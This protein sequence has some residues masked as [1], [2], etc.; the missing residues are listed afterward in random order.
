MV[1]E[2]EPG[3]LLD[4]P[5]DAKKKN[6]NPIREKIDALRAEFQRKIDEKESL[7]QTAESERNEARSAET[8]A[9]QELEDKRAEVNRLNEA[10]R[11]VRASAEEAA[12]KASHQIKQWKEKAQAAER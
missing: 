9:T 8:R 10:V 3:T 4:K 12:N 11:T 6:L 2:N 1:D 5:M 7:L